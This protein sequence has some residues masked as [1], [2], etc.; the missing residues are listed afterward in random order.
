[1]ATSSV[2]G[3]S[4][5]DV[6]QIV[7][8]LMTV[9]RQ[10]L[11]ALASKE[12]AL[13][14]KISAYGALKSA[15]SV[16]Q[17][18]MDSIT[19]AKFTSTGTSSS[20]I[21]VLVATSTSEAAPGVYDLNITKTAASHVLK[22][23]GATSDT[24]Q[25]STGV[26]SLQ[27]GGGAIKSIVIDSS[28]NTLRGVR[29]AINAA[30]AGVDASVVYDGTAYRLVLTAAKSGAANTITMNSG[31]LA[32][33][34][35]KNALDGTTVARAAQNAE[36]TVNG[37]AVSSDSNTNTTAISGVTLNLMKEGSS[38]LSVVQDLGSANGAVQSF[39]KAFNDVQRTITDL[40]KYDATT[41]RAGLLSGDPSTA[42]LV[43]TLR[44]TLTTGLTGLTGKFKNLSDIG[45]SFQKDGTLSLDAAKLTKALKDAPSDVSKLFTRQGTSNSVLVSYSGATPATA[46]GE[47]HVDVTA[48]ATRAAAVATNAPAGSVVIDGTNDTLSV[49]VDGIAS[50]TLGLTRGTYAPAELATLLQNTL[51]GAA[52]FTSASKSVAVTLDG[53]MLKIESQNYGVE[54]KVSDM[55]GS[56]ISALGFDGTETATGSDAAGSLMLDGRGY[57]LTGTGQTLRGETGT[58]SEGL[59][60]KYTGTPASLVAGSD[61]IVNVSEG[62]ATRLA[63]A[64][65]QALDTTGIIASKTDGLSRSLKD[66]GT[67]RESLNNRLERVEKQLRAQYVALDALMG[68]MSKTSSFLTQQLAALPS[69]S[70]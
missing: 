12:T 69:T 16:F 32:A 67:R 27:V 63:R 57:T 35:L 59:A 44:S 11:A 48:A 2:S 19:P 53:G 52:P 60:L 8:Q 3:V 47:Y 54:S 39:V 25:S 64:V 70:S 66:I 13:Q 55:A 65:Q 38:K 61:A 34:E 28:N 6:N 33:G 26:I 56:A 43:A 14:T 15:M 36:F 62:Y 40:T 42:N 7:S 4:N 30:D 1:M 24:T 46:S 18:A 21:S 23:A 17:G 50:G 31:G 68:R 20:E 22:S 10:P 45:V 29:D 41:K 58:K 51:N 5:I 9:E 49:K 37:V